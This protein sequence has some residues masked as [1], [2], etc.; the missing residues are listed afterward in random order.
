MLFT[1]KYTDQISGV[2]HCIALIELLFKELFPVSVMPV[3]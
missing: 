2:L 1:E 3:E